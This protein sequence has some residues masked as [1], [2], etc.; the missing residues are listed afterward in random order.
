MSDNVTDATADDDVDVIVTPVNDPP[1]LNITGTFEAE[2]DLV[3][4]TY[5]FSG[6]CSQTWGET[7][8]LTL[9]ADNSTHIDVTITDFDVVFQSN[10]LNWNGT[11]D[12][13]IYLDDN[14]ADSRDVVSQVIQVTINPVNDAPTIVLPDEFTFDEDGTLVE[15]F[16]AY[17]DDVDPDDL[18]LSVTGNTEITVD[19]V[20]TIVTFS[21]TENWNGTETLTFT[22]SDNVTDATAEDD[23]DVI[24]IPVNDE[25]EI[26]GFTPE[27]L[28]FTVLQ[29]SIVT[30]TVIAE[31]ID[32]D[33]TYEWL[34]DNEL[35]TE[36]TEEFI[37]Q[38]SEL[39][40][41]EIKSVVSDE[42]YSLETIWNI[43]VN[44]TTGLEEI[45]PVATILYQNHPNPFNP[46]TNIRFAVTNAGN[47]SI[48]I[49][50]IKGEQIKTLVNA[51]YPVGEHT[52]VWNGKDNNGKIVSSGVYFYHML[53]KEYSSTRKMI[54]MK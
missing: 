42:E 25:P 52:V 43:T 17:I 5:D 6:F 53:S 32:S 27:E 19:I 2:E 34:V 28:V 20:G 29:D 38:F 30:F 37:Y 1:I 48:N 8:V 10:T 26:I 15:D 21:A 50:N 49:Y 22:V 51:V 23:V 14:V 33:L 12:I 45:I 9:S 44:P 40:V 36:I 39:G 11:E 35:Q 54:L 41:I 31:D 16:A 47:I 4:I 46:T 24:V 3:S 18:T 7:D 13:T